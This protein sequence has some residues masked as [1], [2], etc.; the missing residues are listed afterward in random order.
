MG[1]R[2]SGATPPKLLLEHPA[3]GVGPSGFVDA[4]WPAASERWYVEVGVDNPPDSPHNA[5]LQVLGAGGVPLLVLV[6]AA[7]VAT[8]VLGRRALLAAD[9]E[10]RPLLVG[11]MATLVAGLVALSTGFTHAATTPL[12]ALLAG[13]LVA[14]PPRSEES[15]WLPRA[16][17][18]VATLWFLALGAACVGEVRT[19]D[20]VGLAASGRTAD[21]DAAFA[22]AQRLRPWDPDLALVAT[23]AFA[24]GA[25][26]GDVASAEQALVWS[27]RALARAPGSLEAARTHGIAL[28]TLGRLPEA[29]SVLDGLV[30]EQPNDPSLLVAA[31]TFAA[32]D[33]DLD[34][35]LRDLGR[36]TEID[37]DDELAWTNLGVVAEAAGDA[38]ERL[39]RVR[40][41]RSGG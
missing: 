22:A 29:R 23:E 36:A 31:G 15:R 8:A 1:A 6:V 21:A 40:A 20:G 5:V 2:S 27:E 24:P 25:T 10:R 37:P 17:A 32:Q 35:A 19:A 4:F 34:A 14:V 33:G 30:T 18:A 38:D 16:V 12:L 41:H 26:E 7:V 39:A 9:D 13:A 11:A 3:A 28:A